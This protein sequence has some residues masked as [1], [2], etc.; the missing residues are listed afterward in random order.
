MRATVLV[1]ASLLPACASAPRRAAPP[2]PSYS[3]LGSGHLL[4]AVTP[5]G[6]F[7]TL[8]DGSRWEIHPRDRFQ[9]ESW[10][11]NDNIAVRTTRPDEGYAFEIVNTQTDEGALARMAP[12]N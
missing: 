8:E 11:V 3:A 6:R 10:D 9:T 5:D 2:E 1:L 4:R 12:R 7:V